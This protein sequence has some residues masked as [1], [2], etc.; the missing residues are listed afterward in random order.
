MCS[1]L[2]YPHN[3]GVGVG[4]GVEGEPLLLLLGYKL[5]SVPGDPL[6]MSDW[7]G[8]SFLCLTVSV[9]GLTAVQC[10]PVKVAQ[11]KQTCWQ[12]T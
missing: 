9:I 8:L 11:R 10:L 1:A 5:L 12:A 7:F 6:A 4:V 3:V 2:M